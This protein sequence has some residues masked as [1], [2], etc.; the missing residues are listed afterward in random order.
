MKFLKPDDGV[1]VGE[2]NI[3]KPLR[4]GMDMLGNGKQQSGW[5]YCTSN[6]WLEEEEDISWNEE[7]GELL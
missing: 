2:T 1:L 7:N 3:R 4:D 6:S 5:N